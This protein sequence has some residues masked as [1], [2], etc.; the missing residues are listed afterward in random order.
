MPA[1]LPLKAAER[2]LK[3][4]VERLQQGE[5][6]TLLDADG[7]PLAMLVSLRTE[8]RKPVEDWETAMKALAEQ[9]DEAWQGEASAIE[10]LSEMRR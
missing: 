2:N 7:Q 3:R 8:V 10:T 4:V 9:V 5:S 6:I 1:T